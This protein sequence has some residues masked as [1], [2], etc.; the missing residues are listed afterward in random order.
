M[1]GTD[2]K[3][4]AGYFKEKAVIGLSNFTGDEIDKAIMKAT[5]HAL[6]AP[7]EKY[8]QRLVAASY[9]QYGY[10]LKEGLSHNEYIVRELE[11]RSHT[12]NWVIVLKTMVAFHRLLCDASDDMV[13]TICIFRNV[14]NQSH[15]KNLAQTNDG[16]G[17]AYFIT[18]YMVYL[19]E[20]CAMQN[21]LGKCHRIELPQFEEYLNT[22]NPDTLQPV[23]EVLLR[24]LETLSVVQ[25][26]EVIVNNFCT[27][28]AYQLLVKDGK[29]VF[30]LLAKR[31]IFILDGFEEL[32]LP[33]KKR[34]FGLYR[35]Y[36]SAFLS[37]KAFFDAILRSSKVFVE[38]V[39]QLK[40]LPP[41]LAARLESNIRASE[42]P[43][44]VPCTLA[45]LGIRS[46][47]D[48]RVEPEKEV[49][50]A[51]PPQ[52]QAQPAPQP[53][54]VAP[55]KPVV[56]AFSM[57]DLFVSTPEPAKA[58]PL[59]AAAAFDPWASQQP[60]SSAQPVAAQ[61]QWDSGAPTG[62][63]SGPPQE[64]ASGVPAP[65]QPQSSQQAPALYQ[66]SSTASPA[67][68]MSPPQTASQSTSKPATAPKKANDPF[69]DLYDQSHR[70]F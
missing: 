22:L 23:F 10:K 66:G 53:K 30:Q 18:Q 54:T 35:R 20:R 1:N 33:E 31:V 45:D 12:H 47:E 2:A 58:A 60:V 6:K 39:P 69:K 42:I 41:S 9:G 34:W 26:R 57:D 64:W 56:P 4:S 3:Q 48:K 36:E 44:E 5:S 65:A 7:K 62:W 28:E 52:P 59:P 68:E 8:V 15:L 11:K 37:L 61:A 27:M 43:T 14:F 25:Y 70:N 46:A 38:P 13:E 40:P 24:L 32:T 29:R 55:P 50:K 17:Q 51:T 21:A 63:S 16:A 67:P 49:L 19:E